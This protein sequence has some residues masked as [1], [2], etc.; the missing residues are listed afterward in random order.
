MDNVT[1]KKVVDSA[2]FEDILVLYIKALV[3]STLESQQ[4]YLANKAI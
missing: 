3:I 1:R 2:L 4:A